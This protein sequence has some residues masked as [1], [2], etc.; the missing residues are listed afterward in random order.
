MRIV[1]GFIVL[2]VCAGI[3]GCTEAGETT[4][5]GAAT[6]G[7]LGAGVGALVGNQ[8]GSTVGGMTLGALAGAGAGAAV[9]NALEADQKA[10]K[11]QDQAIEQQERAL[12]AHR[13]EIDELRRSTQDGIS[14]RDSGSPGSVAKGRYGS[15]PTESRN[16]AA[17]TLPGAARG[18]IRETTVIADQGNTPAREV[19]KDSWS[20]PRAAVEAPIVE[21]S[22]GRSQETALNTLPQGEECQ[23]AQTEVRSAQVAAES[24]DKLFHYRRA[25][26]LCPDSAIFHNGLGEVYL[27]LGRRQDAEFEFK[28]ALRLNP[29]YRE[30][31]S[32]LSNTKVQG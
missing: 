14:Y 25:L 20:S 27:S 16:Y 29:D 5:V 8:T 24:A 26:R 17:S 22:L 13:A 4:Q 32:N 12:A 2:S 23:K 6:G 15:M 9:G 11:S 10:L 18:T 19:I 31:Q 28:E 1:N 21:Q 7:V 3:L 30:A